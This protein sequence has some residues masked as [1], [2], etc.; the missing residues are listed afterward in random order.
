MVVLVE[1]DRV[2]RTSAN[3][4]FS[5][6]LSSFTSVETLAAAVAAAVIAQAHFGG[7]WDQAILWEAWD[8]QAG[9]A[10]E[11]DSPAEDSEALEA[12]A[13]AAVELPDLGKKALTKKAT[14]FEV[15]FLFSAVSEL[16]F[17]G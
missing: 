10:V 17:K 2:K 5:S 11:A 14:S 7:V 4:L 1:T 15:A 16:K 8:A 13:S 12:A 6:S 3:S 9:S